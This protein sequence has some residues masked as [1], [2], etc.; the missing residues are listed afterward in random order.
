MLLLGNMRADERLAAFLVNLV[1]RLHARGFSQS[2]VVLRMT[3][4]EIGNYLGM[5]LETV[6]R[7]FSK[8]VED[9]IIDVNQRH[10]TIKTRGAEGPS[11][12]PTLQSLQQPLLTMRRSFQRWLPTEDKLKSSRS[13]RWLGPLLHRPWLWHFNRRTVAAGVASAFSLAF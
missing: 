11:Q 3:R 12:Y 2:E 6:S 4:K 5:Q 13:L 1:Q 7:T 8:F 9:G 10:I